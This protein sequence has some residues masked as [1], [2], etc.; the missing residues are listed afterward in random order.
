MGVTSATRAAAAAT[1]AASVLRARARSA[2]RKT[3]SCGARRRRSH[4]AARVRHQPRPR[5]PADCRNRGRSSTRRRH[6][7]PERGRRGMPDACAARDRR[8]RRPAPARRTPRAG[9]RRST[10][11]AS[12]AGARRACAASVPTRRRGLP[13]S[14][15]PRRPASAPRP[16][17][18]F[19]VCRPPAG[20]VRRLARDGPAPRRGLPAR[21][22]D[23]YVAVPRG[24]GGRIAA[25]PLVPQGVAAARAFLDA[26]AFGPW[27]RS[28][29]NRALAAAARRAGRPVFTTYQIRHSFAAGLRR[30]GTDV[31]DIQDLYG[32][33]RPE[34]TMIYAPP[35]L[36]K[37]H[38]ALERLRENDESGAPSP[39]RGPVFWLARSAGR[40]RRD[41]VT[42]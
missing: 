4:S 38:A 40:A 27:P 25:V 13:R 17:S 16:A 18:W 28:S 42:Y 1:S 14:A 30:A 15:H 8:C 34:T 33:S 23:P 35:E 37:H 11:P 10:T 3:D 19:R 22:A 39:V 31:A 6:R 26:E 5:A 20:S 9:A 2:A 21:R 24:N 12:R 41:S 29:V 36:A 32:H 7:G